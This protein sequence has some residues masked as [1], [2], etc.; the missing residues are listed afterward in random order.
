M[1]KIIKNKKFKESLNLS[2]DDELEIISFKNLQKKNIKKC[3]NFFLIKKMNNKKELID[4]LNEN[5]NGVVFSVNKNNYEDL[6]IE[7]VK[8]M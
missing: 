5:G 7:Y 2:N 1:E 3:D 4:F 8:K 6:R